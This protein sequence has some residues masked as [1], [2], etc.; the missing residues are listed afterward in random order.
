M[1]EEKQ[2]QKVASKND[3]Q[4]GGMLRVQVK[5]KEI[6]LSMVEGKVYAM[7]NICTHRGG[8]LNEGELKGY[9]LKCPWH[10][11]VFDVRNGRVSDR[12]VWATNLNSYPVK[13]EETNGDILVNP[14]SGIKM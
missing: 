3:L 14:D 1:S 7:D 13:V 8:P 9:N 5:N 4:E 12:T 6:V 10:Y 2:Y 11:A